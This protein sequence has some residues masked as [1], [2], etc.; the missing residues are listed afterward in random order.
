MKAEITNYLDF[1]QIR[2][3][4]EEGRNG[5]EIVVQ[6]C[7]FCRDN[8]WHFYINS[9]S[10]FYHCFHCPETGT[11][12]TLKRHLGD[13]AN[14]ISMA[15]LSKPKEEL[16]TDEEW[17]MVNEAH[18]AL[19]RKKAVL[20]YLA[21]RAFTNIAI[22]FFHLGYSVEDGVEWLWYPY[23]K[24][25]RIVN[26]KKRT[27]PPSPKGFKRL[28]GK[29]SALLNEDILSGKMESILICEGESDCI[30]LWSAGIKNCVGVSLGAGGINNEWIEKL[31]KVPKI[32]I[33]F[34]EDE[35]GLQGAYKFVNRLGIERCYRVHLP[36][37]IND[38]NDFFSRG[39]TAEEFQ[40]LVEQAKPFDV[41]Y[42][43]ALKDE[44]SRGIQR[45]Y[46][47]GEGTPGLALP[48]PKLDRIVNK[49]VAGD[50]VV[51]CARPGCGKS[52]FGLNML[53]YYAMQSVPSLMF[54]LEMRPE[55][56]MPRLVARHNHI[57]SKKAFVIEVLRKAYDELIDVPLYFAYVYKKPTYDVCADTI[58]SCVRRYGIQFV[59]FDNL[60][61]LVRSVSDQVREVSLITQNFKLLAEELGIPIVLIARPRKGTNKIITN[62]DLKDSSD[63]EADADIVILLHREPKGE[64]G[65][66]YP[67]F[68]EHEGIF[69][70]RTLVR[71]S[72]SRY[73]IGGQLYLKSIDAECRIEEYQ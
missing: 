33:C 72:K 21:K 51:I 68:G 61:F 5:Q 46:L 59:V 12:F 2:Y 43:S 15:D 37:G 10:G 25:G 17:Q 41:Q 9:Q 58:R 65:T 53:Y 54:S 8:G 6:T 7:P 48:W 35:A 60:H 1:K 69:D 27:L 26:V 11:F 18:K 70:E 62:M 66:D 56:L 14:V 39:R 29:E 38:I 31:D 32:Y 64:E 55:R 73:S 3:Q 45:L 42:V 47:N 4:L 22:E 40:K 24:N 44:I 16:P 36:S 67:Q 71:V 63:V 13:I 57:D 52:Q 20:K 19:L 28:K 49:L 23:I 50:L 30:A 34:D